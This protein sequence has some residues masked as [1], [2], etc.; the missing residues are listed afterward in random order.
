MTKFDQLQKW[1]ADRERKYAHGVA[2]FDA[3][4]R[5]VH[6]EKFAAYFN[7]VGSASIFDPHFTQLVNVLTKISTQIRQE[8]ALYPTAKEEISLTKQEPTPIAGEDLKKVIEEKQGEL[9]S[10]QDE[11]STLQDKIVEL[12]GDS[13]ENADEIQLLQ[14][15]LNEHEEQLDA[16]TKEVEELSKPG[17]KVVTVDSMPKTVKAA[18]ERI[19]V[20]TPLYASLHS[21]IANES[22]SDDERKK[23]ANELCKL[24]DERRKLWDRIDSW[25]EGKIVELD[26]DKPKYSDNDVV[27]GFELLRARKR[28]KE[29]ILNSTKSAEKAEQDGKKT[30]HQNAMDRIEKYK[31][32]LA[33]VEQEIADAGI[34]E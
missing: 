19:K 34:T 17:V 8:P 13:E 2:L 11:I 26:V 24:D 15:K 21:D 16:L 9:E 22:I 3:L 30:V 25:A 6:R 31:A 5:P 28:L 10:C 20:I 27:R 7:Q 32:D 4:A 33:E 12:E 29:N 14:A 1:L 23:F 18:H